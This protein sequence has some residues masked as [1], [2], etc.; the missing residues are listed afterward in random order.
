MIGMVATLT[1]HHFVLECT[2]P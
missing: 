1:I 2:D